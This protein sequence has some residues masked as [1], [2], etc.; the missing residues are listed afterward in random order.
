MKA[1]QFYKSF[2]NWMLLLSLAIGGSFIQVSCTFYDNPAE[3]GVPSFPIEQYIPYLN[4]ANQ[5]ES[6]TAA[7]AKKYE[8]KE[9]RLEV[10][11]DEGG[12]P[13]NFRYCGSAF[14]MSNNAEL[15][16]KDYVPTRE[17]FDNLNISG[18]SRF[19][20]KQLEALTEWA[21]ENVKSKTRI[22]VDLRQETHGFINGNH[23]SWY[24]YINWS[25]IGK[26]H[27]SIINEENALFGSLQ[28]KTITMGKISSSNNY[29][30]TNPKTFTIEKAEDA[31]TEREAVKKQ[32]WLYYR[33]TALD[34]VFACDAVLD[35]FL[36]FYRTLPRD[37]WLHFHCQAGRGR[38]TSFM[39]F[40]DMLRNPDVP[41][42]DILYRHTLIGGVSLTY[43][44]DRPDEQEWRR[45]LFKE[46]SVMVPLFYQYVQDNKSTNYAKSFSQWKR[47][48][49]PGLYE[50]MGPQYS[51]ADVT[52]R[53]I[54]IF[55]ENDVHGGIDGYPMIAGL[56]D[57]VAQSDT[58]WA[59]VVSSGD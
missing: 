23:V 29:V 58:A 51:T 9:W 13:F 52:D 53:S 43:E 46:I 28:G 54:V 39:V 5:R 20:L 31:M 14:D 12:L 57:A 24:G 30:M 10:A 8:G 6:I 18:S 7:E 2:V 47:E 3:E 34:H 32:G 17:G 16:D 1:N 37:V 38:T 55:Y 27:Q 15:Q 11:A 49:F 33:I 21:N 50:P 48:V 59:G 25:N 35:Q 44:G 56:R 45:D 19:S 41:L 36:E 42:K 4:H 26:Q 40:Y 22:I